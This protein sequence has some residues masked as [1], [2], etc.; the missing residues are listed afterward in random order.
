M[1]LRSRRFCRPPDLGGIA[2]GKNVDTGDG[3]GDDERRSSGSSSGGRSPPGA[4]NGIV[5]LAMKND[6]VGYLPSGV[7]RGHATVTQLQKVATP[8]PQVIGVLSPRAR[9][10]RGPRGD[11]VGMLAERRCGPRCEPGGLRVPFLRSRPSNT[12]DDRLNVCRG[13]S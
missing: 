11:L 9:W 6:A 5:D 1:R 12:G 2:G 4:V 8:L 7:P 10:L 3:Y 13:L